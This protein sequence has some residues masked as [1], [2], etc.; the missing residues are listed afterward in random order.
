MGEKKY[1]RENVKVDLKGSKGERRTQGSE[2]RRG[3]GRKGLA[4]W[5]I[6]GSFLEVKRG[7]ASLAREVEKRVSHLFARRTRKKNEESRE[8]RRRVEREGVGGDTVPRILVD[9]R[10]YERGA[11]HLGRVRFPGDQGGAGATVYFR[12][13]RVG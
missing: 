1:R 2:Q 13:P 3:L 7:A 11:T 9:S 12:D 4:K 8:F 6:T 10:R 5:G